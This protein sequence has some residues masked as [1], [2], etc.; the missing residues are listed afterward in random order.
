[1]VTV[2]QALKNIIERFT[3][4]RLKMNKIS[5]VKIKWKK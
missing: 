1:M 5:A 3:T 2:A 4:N